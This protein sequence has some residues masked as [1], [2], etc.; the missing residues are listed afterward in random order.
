VFVNESRGGFI[1]AAEADTSGAA[2]P[3]ELASAVIILD[4]D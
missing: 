3:K 1:S 2:L 4:A